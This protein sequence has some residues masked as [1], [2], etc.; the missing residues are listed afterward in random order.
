MKLGEKRRRRWLIEAWTARQTKAN[1]MRPKKIETE[2]ESESG[3]SAKT[4]PGVLRMPPHEQH[5]N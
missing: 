2:S 3:R 5:L 4:K 1:G